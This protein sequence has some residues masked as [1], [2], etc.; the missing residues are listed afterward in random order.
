M[1]RARLRELLMNLLL[2]MPDRDIYQESDAA[3]AGTRELKQAFINV[4]LLCLV[5]I[6]FC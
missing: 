1:R 3:R 5:A 2:F 6:C 4:F